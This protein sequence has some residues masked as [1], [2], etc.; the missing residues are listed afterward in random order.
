MIYRYYFY[1]YIMTHRKVFSIDNVHPFLKE[2][3]NLID[4]MFKELNKD[5]G[6]IHPTIHDYEKFLQYILE[7]LTNTVQCSGIHLTGKNKNQRCQ[8]IPQPGSKYCLKHRTQD[9]NDQYHPKHQNHDNKNEIENIKEEL[10]SLKIKLNN[11]T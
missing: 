5:K 4:N 11:Q 2:H 9:P 7:Q 1:Y 6:I 3:A 8:A 10:A